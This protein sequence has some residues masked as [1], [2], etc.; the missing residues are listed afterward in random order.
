MGPVRTR[1]TGAGPPDAE[2]LRR[3]RAELI[4]RGLLARP[5]P[6]PAVPEVIERSWRRCV[7]DA[8]PVAPASIGYSDA[9]HLD[10]RLRAAAVPA[11][12]RLGEHLADVPVA[13][14]VSNE[15]GQIA[16]RRAPEAGQRKV[17][18][19]A[20]AA[21]GFDF[22]EAS[23]GTNAL[24]TVIRERRAVVVRGSEHYNELLQRVTCA[25]TPIHEPVTRRILGSFSLACRAE[26]ASPLMAVLAADVAR[27]IESALTAMAGAR[28]QALIRAY[29]AAEQAGNEPVLVVDERTALANTA[30]L[31]H[32]STQT[33]ALLWT[34]LR[35]APPLRG[36]VHTR[37]PLPDGWRDAVV[38]PIGGGEG[39]AAAYC[40]RVLPQP[41]IGA[42]AGTAL[43]RPRRPPEPVAPVH[44][45]A[46]VHHQALAALGNGEVLA[47]DGGPGTGKL[48]TALALLA[49][50]GRR[51]PGP[52]VVD[53]ATVAP[54]PAWFG[55]AAHALDAGRAVVLRHLQDLPAEDVNRAKA[56]A[57]RAA[58]GAGP[59]VLTVRLGVAP[60]PVRE[61]LA[62]VATVVELPPLRD[63]R[64]HLPELVT[65]ILAG[66]PGTAGR[67]R[68]SSEALQAL[69]RWSW[70]GN[71]AELRHLVEV[72]AHRR[73]GGTV[74]PADL[75]GHVQRAASAR[76]LSMIETAERQAILTALHRSGGNRSRAAQ[77]LGI[78][79]TTLYR[80]MQHHRIDG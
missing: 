41:A 70:P 25:G 34:H 37:L 36:P 22:S 3:A 66:L 14:F 42:A 50:P 65:G 13:M 77:A 10:P 5:E 24:G 15:R 32:L 59:V 44:P 40:I 54:G 63:L 20:S 4:E 7:G 11:M 62:Q 45:A 26:D 6:M 35:E 16:L 57:E 21:E 76:Q 8:V 71:L 31:P 51:G 29:L 49:G 2:R 23:V 72:L 47:L 75:P 46:E 78:G 52:L 30:G 58:G 28:E 68:F 17:L 79:R 39:R 33:H 53:L 27:Q 43:P 18:D 9:V 74:R 64:G 69:L 1:T 38:E 60:E 73:A 61:L 12:S 67:T 56:L 80:K 48:H 55:T 19:R